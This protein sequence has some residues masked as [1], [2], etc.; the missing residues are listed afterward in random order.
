MEKERAELEILLAEYKA[1]YDEVY[2]WHSYRHQ[3]LGGYFVVLSILATLIKENGWE[4]WVDAILIVLAILS[5]ILLYILFQYRFAIVRNVIYI[6]SC[7]GPN[8]RKLSTDKV[9][10]DLS[11]CSDYRESSG[12][13]IRWLTKLGIEIV[14]FVAYVFALIIFVALFFLDAQ[15]SPILVVLCLLVFAV[16]LFMLRWLC[17]SYYR[18]GKDEEQ[19]SKFG[20]PGW[21]NVGETSCWHLVYMSIGSIVKANRT[22]R[23]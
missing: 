20:S 19:A 2:K 22:K 16:S 13:T 5:L 17:L 15:S 3:A 14:P 12:V 11:V 8:L 23:T 1:H 21:I 9:L 4:E 6:N 7:L 10:G 18:I